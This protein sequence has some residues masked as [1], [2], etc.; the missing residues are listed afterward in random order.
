MWE[1]FFYSSKDASLSVSVSVIVSSTGGRLD[2]D[3]FVDVC[4]LD[5]STKFLFK[6]LSNF[7]WV[8]SKEI[9]SI[10]WNSDNILS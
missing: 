4:I 2:E 10:I 8:S 6:A 1:A 9:L 3:G 5:W 7:F